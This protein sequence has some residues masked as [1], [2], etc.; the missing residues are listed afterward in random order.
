MNIIK[1]NVIIFVMSLVSLLMGC[2]IQEMEYSLEKYGEE[3]AYD[4]DQNGNIVTLQYPMNTT[5]IMEIGSTYS[6]YRAISEYALVTANQIEGINFSYTYNP[7]STSQFTF[8]RGDSAS[9]NIIVTPSYGDG[10]GSTGIFTKPGDTSVIVCSLKDN[11]VTIATNSY[12]YFLNE[13]NESKIYYSHIVY[14]ADLMDL[15]TSDEKK[16]VALHELGHT[17][18]LIDYKDPEVIGYTVMYYQLTQ[19]YVDYS[20]GDKYNLEWYYSYGGN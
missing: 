13:Y 10:C 14:Y 5:Y 4:I 15:L 19:V 3:K 6:V 7:L 1:I 20:D 18:G 8:Y 16:T 17:L 2:T 11:D 12:D 9:P